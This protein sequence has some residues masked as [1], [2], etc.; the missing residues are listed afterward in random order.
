MDSKVCR[1][2][3]FGPC[4]PASGLMAYYKDRS[5]G[6]LQA[7][8]QEEDMTVSEVYVGVISGRLCRDGI[9]GGI[10]WSL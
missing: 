5:H 7:E 4:D 8:N 2:D 9:A 1:L 6:Q 3:P 10:R